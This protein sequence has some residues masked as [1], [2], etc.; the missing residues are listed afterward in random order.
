MNVDFENLPQKIKD[1]CLLDA[2]VNLH[3]KTEFNQEVIE[4]TIEE[5]LDSIQTGKKFAKIPVIEKGE[6]VPGRVFF[7]NNKYRIM[8]MNDTVSFNIYREYPTWQPYRSFVLFI[9]EAL[10]HKVVITNID[11][12][13]LSHFGNIPLFENIDGVFHLNHLQAFKGAQYSFQCTAS[14]KLPKTTPA[15]ATVVLT[16]RKEVAK[17]QTE[18]IIDIAV[19]NSFVQGVTIDDVMRCLDFVHICE[20]H[21][22]FTIISDDFYNRLK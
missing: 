20:K 9:L 7:A 3:F 11:V 12:R 22:F 8:V 14:G 13:Y 10:V 19:A 15:V 21:L 6:V 18:S 2:M 16:D 4:R 5:R 17:G 1:D